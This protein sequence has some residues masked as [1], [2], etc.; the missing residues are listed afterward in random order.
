MARAG[1]GAL[2]NLRA[3]LAE[4]YRFDVAANYLAAAKGT[5]RAAW[6]LGVVSTETWHR[7]A[8]V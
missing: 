2:I 4:R 1:R 6:L 7:A 8:E 3:R 5:L